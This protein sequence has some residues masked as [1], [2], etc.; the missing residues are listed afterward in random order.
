MEVPDIL[1]EL[2]SLHLFPL[3]SQFFFTP[4]SWGTLNYCT[5][6][7]VAGIVVRPMS[8]AKLIRCPSE[9]SG[10]Y[11]DARVSLQYSKNPRVRTHIFWS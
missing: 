5:L 7:Y 8:K 3:D 11:I 1:S 9:A 6:M 2:Y 10:E 4:Y